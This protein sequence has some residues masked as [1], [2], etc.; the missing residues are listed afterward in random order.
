MCFICDR[1]KMTQEG[2]NPYFVK[3][4]E[5]GYVV[6]GDYQHFKGYSL[7]LYRDHVIELFDLDAETRAKHLREMTLV[8]EAVKNAFGAQKM[9]YEC[10]GNGDGGA[11]IH[12]HLFPRR[13]GDIENYGNNGRGPVWCYPMD[14]MYSDANRPGEEELE[15]MKSKLLREL[16][17][18]I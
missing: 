14:K 4:L 1:I 10:L 13:D 7:F 6:I 18:L 8:A 11:H 15:V 9:N 3:E 17:R 2:N 5:T 16:D 12:W